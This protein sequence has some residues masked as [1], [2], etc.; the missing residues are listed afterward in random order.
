MCRYHE[1]GHFCSHTCA[2]CEARIAR[3]QRSARERT[4]RMLDRI[5]RDTPAR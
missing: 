3:R 5:M 1:T 2:P 4:A